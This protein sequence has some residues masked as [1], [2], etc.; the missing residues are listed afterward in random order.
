[1]SDAHQQ[2]FESRGRQTLQT[3]QQ[4][5]CE[6]R[7]SRSRERLMKRHNQMRSTSELNQ[8]LED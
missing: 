4:K 5:F 2:S 3:I 7:K 8:D 6:K 1:M